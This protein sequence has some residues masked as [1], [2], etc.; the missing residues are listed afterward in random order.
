MIIQ[1]AT[2]NDLSKLA[3]VFNDYRV[4]FN[5]SGDV[6]ATNSFLQQLL[7]K[8]QAIV[9]IAID[10]ETTEIMGFT[11][12]YPMFSSLKLQSTWTLNDMYVVEKYRKYGVASQLLVHVKAFG[13]ETKVAWIMLKTGI[14][15]IKA[16]A[17]YEK[18]G[19]HKDQEHLYY[20]LPIN[21]EG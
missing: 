18:F 12:L 14:E 6:V 19:F 10:E 15:N 8:S 4:H 21:V 3:P 16:Q 5:K 7:I 17:L 13:I 2:L 20:Y 11:L 9:F 1:Q